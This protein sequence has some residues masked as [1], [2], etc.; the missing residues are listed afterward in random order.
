MAQARNENG[1]GNTGDCYT[2]T[3]PHSAAPLSLNLRD[4]ARDR[5]PRAAPLRWMAVLVY[6]TGHHSP[7]PAFRSLPFF[8][9]SVSGRKLAPSAPS[10]KRVSRTE[11]GQL[12]SGW[13]HS[14]PFPD[15]P[16]RKIHAHAPLR[17]CRCPICSRNNDVRRILREGRR[18]RRG[19]AGR[20]ARPL[21]GP[22][23]TPTRRSS[24]SCSTTTSS[25]STRTATWTPRRR[26]SSRWSAASATTSR[27]RA[28]IETMRIF[29]DV[30]VIRGKA[31]VTRRRQ[32]PVAGP[33][34]S[35]TPTSGCGKTSRW[36]MT[37]WR[38]ARLPD[39]PPRRPPK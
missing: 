18:S 11:S 20:R 2:M 10:L 6:R 7:E 5:D 19:V 30:G 35:A 39:C 21:R 17:R 32:R 38:S 29:G 28:S 23:R 15:R 26:S 33:A 1:G 16:S 13:H 34:T 22:G 36:Q 12:A 24:G 27:P 25:T 8:C 3:C 31:K 9:L 14:S 37:A 4:R